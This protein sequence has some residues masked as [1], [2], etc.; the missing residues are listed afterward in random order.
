MG[1]IM[2]IVLDGCDAS[3]KTSI[4]K[5]IASRLCM[6]Y[7]KPFE[8]MLGPDLVTLSENKQYDKIVSIYNS[9]DIPDNSV[10]IVTG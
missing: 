4:A 3:G 7:V 2:I 1:S 6:N 8:G 9:L 10:V 5:S